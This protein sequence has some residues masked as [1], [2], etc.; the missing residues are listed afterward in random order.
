MARHAW[1]RCERPGAGRRWRRRPPPVCARGVRHLMNPETGQRP[2][3][4]HSGKTGHLRRRPRT[5]TQRPGWS[6]APGGL[7]EDGHAQ[8]RRTQVPS[9]RALALALETR[10][11]HSRPRP[12]GAAPRVPPKPQPCPP[13]WTPSHDRP[14]TSLSARPCHL[15]LK[16]AKEKSSA[17]GVTPPLGPKTAV[18]F[19]SVRHS[20]T[21][22]AK[23]TKPAEFY[24]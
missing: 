16:C 4:V 24:F 22:H 12:N 10:S 18:T 11:P 14:R 5:P 20:Q 8:R 21:R 2:G 3:H 15:Q 9:A 17:D 13:A 23:P 1:R 7:P 6:S 19:T